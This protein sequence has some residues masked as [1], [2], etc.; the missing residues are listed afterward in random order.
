MTSSPSPGASSDATTRGRG[1]PPPVIALVVV[2]GLVAGVGLIA[3]QTLG[4]A[5]P[6][7]VM[8]TPAPAGGAAAATVDRLLDALGAA[9]L[10]AGPSPRPYRPPETTALAGVPRTVLQV[11]LPQDPAHGYIVVYELPSAAQA[12]AV[13]REYAAYLGSGVGRV[14]FPIDTRFTL[15]QVDSTLVFFHWSPSNWPD[16]RSAGIQPVI[17]GVGEP[18]AVPS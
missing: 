3:V 8:R 17:E 14:N 10:Q 15:R 18:I 13:G 7:P 6:A 2:L 11:T 12:G 9:Q 4:L 5:T 16:P 1:G